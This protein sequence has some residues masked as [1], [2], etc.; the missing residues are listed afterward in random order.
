M[1]AFDD[2]PRIINNF[3]IEHEIPFS[4]NTTF[5]FQIFPRSSDE[6][7]SAV[8]VVAGDEDV[9]NEE[10]MRGL[11]SKGKTQLMVEV[12]NPDSEFFNEQNITNEL[13]RYFM[14]YIV[15]GVM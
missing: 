13:R 12:F 15:T 8:K 1:S 3:L 11:R 14:K 5:H 7:I 2:V 6:A 4:R 9:I 10:P